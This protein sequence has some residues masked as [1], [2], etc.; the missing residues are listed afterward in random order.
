MKVE[1]E[2]KSIGVV[3]TIENISCEVNMGK[4][5]GSDELDA[6]VMSMIL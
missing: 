1:D 2:V 5:G 3:S 6:S 4:V